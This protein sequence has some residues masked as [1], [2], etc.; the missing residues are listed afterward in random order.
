[1]L[2]SS[3][4]VQGLGFN[5]EDQEFKIIFSYTGIQDQPGM[6]GTASKQQKK[7]LLKL[8]L[9]PIKA[10]FLSSTVGTPVPRTSGAR[11]KNLQHS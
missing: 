9:K 2:L 8:D 1:M 3:I 7:R 6:H 4:Y 11:G 10:R 5:S